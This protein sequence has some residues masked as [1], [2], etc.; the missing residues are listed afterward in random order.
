M[1]PLAYTYAYGYKT[2]AQAHMAFLNA[3]E[4]GE[5]SQCELFAFEP[6]STPNG[7]RWRIMLCA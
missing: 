4:E 2:R 6:Y 5:V 3:C 7:R 1:T